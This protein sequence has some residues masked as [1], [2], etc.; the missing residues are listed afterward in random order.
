MKL[1]PLFLHIR[2]S[3]LSMNRVSGEFDMSIQCECFL[4]EPRLAP[5]L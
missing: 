2:T 4:C 1:C 3:S 5:C